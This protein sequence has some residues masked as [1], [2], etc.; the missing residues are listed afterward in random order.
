MPHPPISNLKKGYNR[1][2]QLTFSDE[3]NQQERLPLHIILGAADYQRIKTTEPPVLGPEP[4][5]DPGA[6]FTMLGWTLSGRVLYS[7]FETE[8][9]F[10]LKS[11]RDEFEQMCSL[12]ALGLMDTPNKQEAF[13][14]DFTDK[15]QQLEGGTYSTRM[16]WKEDA[17]SLPTNKALAMARLH[18]ATKILETLGRLEEYHSIMEYCVGNDNLCTRLPA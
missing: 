15:L 11:M 14:K 7:S 18:S 9:T 1:L 16:P 12:E 3:G 6:E 17:S 8:K 13:H 5:K 4:N 2:R 10:F